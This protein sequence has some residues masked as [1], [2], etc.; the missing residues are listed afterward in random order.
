MKDDILNNLILTLD[1]TDKPVE[2]LS[3]PNGQI[4][5]ESGMSV[6]AEELRQISDLS[7]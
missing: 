4:E 2:I 3:N 1:I 7:D 5:I 6:T